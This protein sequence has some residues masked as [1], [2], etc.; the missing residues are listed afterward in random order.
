MTAV[1]EVEVVRSCAAVAAQRVTCCS[2]D[3]LRV[4]NKGLVT[5]IYHSAAQRPLTRVN[6]N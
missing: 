3:N 4:A 2:Y 1:A 5:C 6:G